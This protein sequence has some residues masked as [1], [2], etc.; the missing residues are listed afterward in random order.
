LNWQLNETLVPYLYHSIGLSKISLLRTESNKKYLFGDAISETYALGIKKIIKDS[1]RYS[2]Y[3]L[4]YGAE[5]KCM[6][7][8]SLE[9]RDNRNFSP[10][11]S[12]DMRGISFNITF[13]VIFGADRTIG[14]KAFSMLIEN[15][16]EA[17]IPAFEEYIEKYPKHGR[18][19]KAKK[20][21]DFCRSQIPYKK[22]NEGINQLDEKNLDKTVM[23]FDEAYIDADEELKFEID[24]KK[25]LLGR[26]IVNYV[27]LNFDKMPLKKCEILLDKAEELSLEISDDVRLLRGKLFF[28]R[29]TLLHESNLFNDA[30]DNYQIALSYNN[31]LSVSIN[32]RLISLA[33]SILDNSKVYYLNNDYVLAVESL[34]K[35]IE[36]IPELS[37]RF[38]PKVKEFEEIILQLNDVKTR[39]AISDVLYDSQ[40]KGRDKEALVIGMF[41][42]DI[43]DI[44]GIPDDINFLESNINTIEV[45]TYSKSQKKLY[46]NQEK[47][48]QIEL[49]EE[50]KWENIFWQLIY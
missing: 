16:Y 49:L 6:R 17:A 11:T 1:E 19:K 20:M 27:E 4:Y 31:N 39:D 41:K 7:T 35:A 28:N 12:F 43:I 36:I 45:W 5:L 48:Y 32:S 50:W 46:I 38:S 44:M 33:N 23:M 40:H 30:L 18:I 42:D 13:G 3:N 10:I 29:A 25:D 15:K 24:F 26:E 8:T 21:L 47:L 34:K 14:D 37:I 2:R 22:Y 9:I